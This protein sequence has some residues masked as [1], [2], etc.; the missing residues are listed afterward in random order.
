[1]KYKKKADQEREFVDMI[2]A[3]GGVKNCICM[4]EGRDDFYQLEL[5]N[6]EIRYW[7]N[8]S[9]ESLISLGIGGNEK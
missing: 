3:K 1:M 7:K 5:K 4:A 2:I 9:D 6:G 8:F